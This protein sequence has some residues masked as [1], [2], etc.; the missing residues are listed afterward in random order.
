MVT[1]S[2]S[3]T[4]WLAMVAMAITFS[5]VALVFAVP[6]LGIRKDHASHAALTA[7]VFAVAPIPM[8]AMVTLTAAETTTASLPSLHWRT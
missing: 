4:T 8:V 1:A 3:G 2:H 5:I 6:Q 7:P